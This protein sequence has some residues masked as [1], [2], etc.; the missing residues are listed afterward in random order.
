MIR[1]IAA[2]INTVSKAAKQSIVL[3]CLA[4]TALILAAAALSSKAGGSPRLGFL[5]ESMAKTAVTLFAEGVF[6]GLLGD[7]LLAVV[8]RGKK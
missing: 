7:F 8:D 5:C 1:K 3:G 2:G 4:G 6:F